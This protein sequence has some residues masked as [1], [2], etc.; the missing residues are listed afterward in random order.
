MTIPE[1]D[2][3]LSHRP[4]LLGERI[5]EADL[6]LF[7]TLVRYDSIYLPLF[8]CTPHRIDDFKNLTAFIKRMMALPGVSDTFNL[9]KSMHHYY[10]SHAHINPSRIVPVAP[11]LSWYTDPSTVSPSRV[12]E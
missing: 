1:L 7:A 12:N 5:T 9:K 8:Q 10:L 4:Y 3:R 6:I 2:E 11:R